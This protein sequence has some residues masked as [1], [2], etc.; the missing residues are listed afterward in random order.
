MTL[1]ENYVAAVL[2]IVRELTPLEQFV[3]TLVTL[4]LQD[5]D[6]VLEVAAKI[7]FFHS[8]DIETPLV[9]VLTLSGKDLNVDNRSVDSRRAGKR[10]I[11]NVAG[12]FTEDR[13]KQFFLRRE[14]CLALR[15]HLSDQDR[16]R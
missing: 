12:L 14:L 5:A 4:F 3:D 9:L 1:F 7:F 11:L 13:T 15:C 10:C 6:L 8:L 16:S 2:E